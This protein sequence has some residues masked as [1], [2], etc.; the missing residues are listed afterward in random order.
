MY[1]YFII[2]RLYF[3]LLS[4]NCVFCVA[5]A[6]PGAQIVTR[7][8]IYISSRS[9]NMS[10][11]SRDWK[12]STHIHT[13]RISISICLWIGIWVLG[14]GSWVLSLAGGFHIYPGS[15]C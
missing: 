1:I 6:A 3:T 2:Y 4:T 7:V 15:W 11:L 14:P 5:D 8:Y 9:G 13:H 10:S 12:R